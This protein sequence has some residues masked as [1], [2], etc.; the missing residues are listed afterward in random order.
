M[1]HITLLRRLARAIAVVA[2]CL[3]L[4]LA[5]GSRCFADGLPELYQVS[6]SYRH[7]GVDDSDTTSDPDTYLLIYVDGELQAL[8]PVFEGQ[9]HQWTSRQ[10]V[11]L[12][13]RPGSRVNFQVWDADLESA[14]DPATIEVLSWG[15][16][17]ALLLLTE[18]PVLAEMA[19][20]AAKKLLELA[21]QID[22]DD[23]LMSVSVHPR[24]S[25]QESALVDLTAGDDHLGY[26]QYHAS[27]AS[28][29]DLECNR[30]ALQILW[31]RR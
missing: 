12:A 2:G 24:L 10:T 1:C 18:D 8:T 9:G 23:Y 7:W 13:L 5:S 14:L 16:A 22:G 25:G 11:T 3:V 4:P 15:A 30:E 26:L 28:T 20:W 27:P 21:S 17:I 31:A 19:E 6:A 29:S